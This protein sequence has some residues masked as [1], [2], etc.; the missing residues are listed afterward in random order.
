MTMMWLRMFSLGYAYAV[1]VGVATAGMLAS[2]ALAS[3]YAVLL[4]GVTVLFVGAGTLFLVGSHASSD[5]H[6]P[7]RAPIAHTI[8]PATVALGGAL[9]TLQLLSGFHRPLGMALTSVGVALAVYCQYVLASPLA[10][11]P[12][13]ARLITDL[14]VYLAA[15]L[16][17]VVLLNINSG[18]LL[19][20]LGL[21]IVS[22]LLCLE[23]FQGTG[24]NPRRAALYASVI[25]VLMAQVSWVLHYE[26]FDHVVT[27]LLLL[28][29]FYLL[30]GLVHNH[31]LNR[32][33]RGVALEFIGVTVLGLGL[34][35]T[36]RTL[37]G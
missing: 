3:P 28:L 23:L 37:S 13:Y 15:F 27:G 35:Y 22:G 33:S 19:S 26:S 4:V 32:L 16:L 21:G 10:R 36:F 6:L 25:G 7:R 34:L 12:A 31:L 20:A 11:K 29:G 2:S 14:S 1:V 18:P 17:F 5:S 8:V 24:E 9:F 30:S